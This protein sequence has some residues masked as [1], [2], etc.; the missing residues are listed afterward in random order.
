M[1]HHN[2]REGRRTEQY[3]ADLL[4]SDPEISEVALTDYNGLGDVT[5]RTPDSKLRTLQVKKMSYMS[6]YSYKVNNVTGYP[7]DMLVVCLND[8]RQ[9]GALFTGQDT[10]DRPGAGMVLSYGPGKKTSYYSQ[11][12]V[13]WSKFEEQLLSRCRT[14]TVVE[15]PDSLISR[16]NLKEK[17]MIDRFA[18]FCLKMRYAFVRS[19]MSST[20]DGTVDGKKVQLKYC[21]RPY[22][23]YCY[24]VH[25]TKHDGGRKTQPYAKG[26]NDYYVFEVGSHEGKFLIV[27]EGFLITKGFLR[28]EH[29]LGKKALNVY[30]PGYE[31]KQFITGAWTCDEANWWDGLSDER[32]IV[33]I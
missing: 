25:L 28:T 31:A 32:I 3:V 1:Q 30:P 10:K 11:F 24:R 17:K 8:E 9:V 29:Q 2:I 20:H 15:D 16:N 33:W 7:D 14:S 6:S 12:R 22:N 4:S 26:D 18:E 23:G 19:D 27:R 21:S 13:E 5:Y